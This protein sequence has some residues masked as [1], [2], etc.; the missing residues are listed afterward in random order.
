M[1][2]TGAVAPR[3]PCRRAR[4]RPPDWRGHLLTTALVAAALP[5]LVA[6][7]GMLL[8]NFALAV[9]LFPLL[10]VLLIRRWL[11][12][13]EELGPG[14][15]SVVGDELVVSGR[16]RS[17]R[18][19]VAAIRAGAASGAA[20]AFELGRGRCV[21]LELESDDDAEALLRRTGTD[22]EQRTL[23]FELRSTIGPFVAGLLFFLGLYGPVSLALAWAGRTL[24]TVA[25]STSKALPLLLTVLL[26]PVLSFVL[27]WMLARARVPTV[28][29]G[30]DG[31]TLRRWF[32]SRFI[33][34]AAVT[35][36]EPIAPPAADAVYSGIKLTLGEEQ[37]LLW[38]IGYTRGELERALARL[39]QARDA[40]AEAREAAPERDAAFVR[41]GHSVAEWRE[42]LLDAGF[43]R[44]VVTVPDAEAVLRD[45]SQPLEH[46]AGAAIALR[47]LDP[48]R[49]PERIRIAA[50][51]A[52]EP[53]ARELLM[54][55]LE[56][57]AELERALAKLTAATREQPR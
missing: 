41:R 16:T 20:L 26:A 48:E 27:A 56:E 7:V 45:P 52:A 1:G 29:I 30:Q 51:V 9:W 8:G 5:A 47:A 43:R 17:A 36:V 31:L 44:R 49:A 12:R 22:V 24:A 34:H 57:D 40:Y 54:A 19:A 18:V 21:D 33:P 53:R 11:R 46:R 4:L 28:T 32:G 37:L 50:D 23:S 25:G 35:R 10:L 6:V 13:R 2:E 14:F 15:V 38:T 42:Q 39:E 3:W 55:T